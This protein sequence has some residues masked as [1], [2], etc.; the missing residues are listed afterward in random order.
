MNAVA[1]F[2]LLT[3]NCNLSLRDQLP[4]EY[5]PKIEEKH[6]G[7]LA[8]HWIPSNPDLWNISNYLD[9]LAERRRLLSEETNRR[10]EE[11][12][13]GDTRWLADKSASTPPS[14]QVP[15]GITSYEEEIL[16]E[17]LNGWIEE[18]K[19][20]RG[21]TSFGYTNPGTGEQ[22]A[23]FDLA[24]PNGLQESFSQPVAV[25][26]DEAP[27]TIAIAARAGFQC[28]TRVDDF[29]TYVLT[30]IAPSGFV[31]D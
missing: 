29:K 26:L 5:F 13:H 25:L 19:L 18:R 16:I 3:K 9:F 27:E 4:S 8:S 12:L 14:K 30:E 31:A 11:L 17:E 6:P 28:F 1:N 20:P 2:S 24:W 10:L 7:A 23:V 21:Q 22:L 15:G